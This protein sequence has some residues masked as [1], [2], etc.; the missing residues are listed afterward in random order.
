M[1]V[2]LLHDVPKVG[3]KYDVTDVSAGYARNFLLP[4]SLAE[5]ATE[6][7]I[8]KYGQ[9]K[10]QLESE[11]KIQEDLLIK[12]LKDMDGIT[13]TVKEKANDQGH[14]FAGLHKEELVPIIKEQ[15][16]LDMAPG[17]ID[18]EKPIKETG[19]HSIKVSVGKEAAVFTLLVEKEED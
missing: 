4:K 19:E 7:S 2:I 10:T 16:H 1:K 17:H 18:L 13:I 15:T 12:N 14:L 9:E 8:K 3:R 6:G 5:F 11:R